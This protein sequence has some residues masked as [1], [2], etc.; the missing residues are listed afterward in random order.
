MTDQP[1]V[2]LPTARRWRVGDFIFTID[3][4]RSAFTA[5]GTYFD[6]GFSGTH[7]W[8]ARGG[9]TLRQF[10]IGLADRRY[11]DKSYF[12]N[13][14]FCSAQLYEFDWPKTRRNLIRHT[15]DGWRDLQYTKEQA[16]EIIDALR[17]LGDNPS[18]EA[19]YGE[20]TISQL[21]EQPWEYRSTN[22]T[23]AAEHCW[24]AFCRFT[25]YLKAN[26]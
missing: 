12:L 4:A 6:K 5:D 2:E 21:V 3:E 26:P 10:L 16:H 18:E 22:L 1:I 14:L 7:H 17:W 13:K 9:Q 20:S 23:V 11:P 25:E 15:V 19:L 24:E 8:D